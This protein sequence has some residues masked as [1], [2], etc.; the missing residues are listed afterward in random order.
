MGTFFIPFANP[1][2]PWRCFF[3]SVLLLHVGQLGAQEPKSLGFASEATYL[4]TIPRFVE[5]PK[6]AFR[7][8]NS[9]FRV[10]IVGGK[11]FAGTVS[12]LAI[13]ETVR[14]KAILILPNPKLNQ[15]SEC[16]ELFLSSMPP[17][18]VRAIL[19]EIAG[20]PI[21]TVGETPDFLDQGGMIQFFFAETLHFKID[22]TAARNCGLGLDS[23]F[24][25]LASSVRKAPD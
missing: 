12:R 16:Q 23:T 24:L 3:L 2:T 20:R 22:L 18:R 17:D 4:L 6:S 1:K 21:L 11:E 10:C 14:G 19:K 13:G 7:Q 9:S 8:P 25:A 15:L 5:W